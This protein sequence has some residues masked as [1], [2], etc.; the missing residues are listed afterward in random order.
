MT[1]RNS[2]SDSDGTIASYDW[3]FGDESAHENTSEASHAYTTAGTYTLTLTVTDDQDGT[4]TD[5]M[6]V[7]VYEDAFTFDLTYNGT[8][9]T[10]DAND[11]IVILLF[12]E[13]TGATGVLGYGGEAIATSAGSISISVD[14][15]DH[16]SP[17]KKYYA[18]FIHY[19]G[20][21]M[22]MPTPDDYVAAYYYN[23]VDNV[24]TGSDIFDVTDLGYILNIPADS[25]SLLTPGSYSV[26][27]SDWPSFSGSGSI[28]VK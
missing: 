28:I 20:E 24:Y 15:I 19:C 13:T 17:Y 16:F 12:E 2:S 27:A 26:T 14:D 10:L 1:F 22:D 4:G 23:G 6:Q 3:D 11:P 5:S 7:T 25:N 9:E 8:E 21:G 18:L